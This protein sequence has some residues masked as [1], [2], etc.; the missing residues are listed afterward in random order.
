M[1]FSRR[2]RSR[3]NPGYGTGWSDAG[4]IIPWTSWIQT[5]DKHV[6][7]ENWAGMEKYLAAIQAANP[8]YLWKKNYGIP[9][10]R[11]AFAG[12]RDAGRPDRDGILGLRR[13]AD[14]ADGACAGKTADE[15]KYGELFEKIKSRL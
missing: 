9:F 3:P 13:Y 14:A 8:D 4:V 12:R 6:I 11:L 10:A 1:A 5:G 2:A 15:Q 7:E